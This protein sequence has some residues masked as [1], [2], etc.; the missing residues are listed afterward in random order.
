MVVL[1]GSLRKFAALGIVVRRVGRSK[2]PGPIELATQI[3][4]DHL[5]GHD[6]RTL[7]RWTPYDRPTRPERIHPTRRK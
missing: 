7:R 3:R 2:R 1:D 4:R 5:W 6:A